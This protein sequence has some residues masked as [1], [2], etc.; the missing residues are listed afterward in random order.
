[1]PVLGQYRV[2][3]FR[4]YWPSTG[5][6]LAQYRMPALALFT[7][8]VQLMYWAST[9]YIG[10]VLAQYCHVSWVS[11]IFEDIGAKEVIT[12]YYH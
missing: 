12:V 11:L 3:T 2:G 1:M 6:A 5:P 4:Q 10:P 8:A 7:A 9:V